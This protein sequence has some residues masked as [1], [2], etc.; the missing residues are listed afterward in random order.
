LQV[1]FSV[2][3]GTFGGGTEFFRAWGATYFYEATRLIEVCLEAG[4]NFFDTVDVYCK[5]FRG[6]PR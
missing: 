1:P 2:W 6:N 3:H 4:V 5:A